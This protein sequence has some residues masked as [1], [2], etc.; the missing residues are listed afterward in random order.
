MEKTNETADS[1]ARKKTNPILAFF[2]FVIS[3]I[4]IIVLLVVGVLLFCMIDRKS[5]LSVL[6]PDYTVYVHTDSVWGT[7]EPLLDLQAA[8]VLLSSPDFVQYRQPFMQFRASPLRQN[9]VLAFLASRA[10]DVTL[11]DDGEKQ[12]V[13]AALNLSFL[14]FATRPLAWYATLLNVPNLSFVDDAFSFLQYES[15]GMTIYI[16]PYKNLVIASDDF[17]LFAKAFADT[18]Y[19]R[20][21]VPRDYALLTKKSDESVRVVVDAAKLVGAAAQG[22]E[23]LEKLAALLDQNILSVISF[24]ITDEEIK[25]KTEIPLASDTENPTALDALI[26]HDS[27]MPALI[28]RMS[29]IVQYY[30]ILNAGSLSE[31]KAA[32][33]P[34]IP[35]S[36]DAD[37]LWQTADR[38]CRT[39]FSLSAE[40]LLFSWSGKEFAVLGVEGQT[41][42]VFAIQVTDEK[43]RQAVFDKITSSFLVNDDTSLIL[44]GVRLPKLVFPAFI[45]KLLSLFGVSLPS[46]YYMVQDGFIY[47]SE[48][49][50]S[51]SALY[52]TVNDGRRLSKD[53]NWNAVSKNQKSDATV[54][55][56]YDLEHSVPFFL[57]GDDDV[58]RILKLYTIGRADMRL[59][60]GVL[61]CQLDAVARRSGDLREI[62]GFPIAL[63]KQGDGELQAEYQKNPEA[64]FWVENGNTIKSLELASMK[65]SVLA[66]PDDCTIVAAKAKQKGGGVL[67]AVSSHGAAYLLTRD[68]QTV[69][70]FPVI[71][72]ELP[73]APATVSDGK[74]VVPVQ[75]GLLFVT[76]GGK[77]SL[78]EHTLLGAIKAAPSVSANGKVVAVYDKGFAGKILLAADGAFTQADGAETM[79]VSGIAYGSPAVIGTKDNALVAFV[80][81]SGNLYLWKNGALL[82]GFPQKLDGVFYTNIVASERYFYA[83]SDTAVLYR[84]AQDGSYI[85]VAI[86]NAT[87]KNAFLTV[88]DTRTPGTYG[89][90]VC[91]DGNMIYGFK[92]NLEMI[93]GF[94]LAGWGR[95]VFADV[96]GDKTIDL[97][98]LTMDKKLVGWNLR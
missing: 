75:Q 72:N 41:D 15:D 25:V 30:T 74:L 82:D 45:Q 95:P 4:L 97:L 84:I 35:P 62:P 55:L 68:L 28:T 13:V 9:K 92:E 59:K 21:Y 39:L 38:A 49:S 17:S 63:E 37:G 10:I 73:T 85:S 89:V 23:L 6:P 32:V 12:H 66:L 79:S 58:K 76:D 8:E 56:Y 7:V 86:P 87:A 44:G 69:S 19:T 71:L 93:S 47:F 26:A 36:Q 24:D 60:K 88:T 11:Y 81:Q 90:Y 70:G 67:W 43:Q 14:S 77:V 61:S 33:F 98:A 46:P 96:N 27:T 51:L 29:D 40:D 5:A 94:P 65:Q 53:K 78:A 80:T 42:P 22:D 48:S 3:L 83:L 64:V 18:D 2:K 16:K 31:L 57:R 52:T 91:A 1:P 20:S 54:S 50:E 34:L